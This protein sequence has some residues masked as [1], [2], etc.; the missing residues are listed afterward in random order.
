[1]T[2]PDDFITQQPQAWLKIVSEMIESPTFLAINGGTVNG[3]GSSLEYT[4]KLRDVL[5]GFL[6]RYQISTILDAPCGDLTWIGQLDLGFLYSYIGFDVDPRII[7]SNRVRFGAKPQ[8]TFAVSNLLTRKRVPKVDV[9]LCRHFLQH[10]TTEYMISVVE[11]F[12]H[13]RSRYLLASNYPG[14]SNDFDYNPDDYPW[15]GYLER[16]HD[17]TAEPFNLTR[18][19]GIPEHSPPGGVLAKKH[20]LAL[21][22]L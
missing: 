9:I 5:P 8:F 7:E 14:A 22:E 3:P 1:M 20:E 4:Q 6:R 21:F 17:L 19:D 11:K 15:L 16:A 18:I 10:L 2:T 12:Q 13:S